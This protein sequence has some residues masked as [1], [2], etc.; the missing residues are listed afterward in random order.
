LIKKGD[1]VFFADNSNGYL[2]RCRAFEATTGELGLVPVSYAGVG[3]NVRDS[4]VDREIRDSFYG[5]QAIVL[6]F[7]DL[8]DDE[9]DHADHWALPELEPALK[10]GLPCLVY[11]SNEFPREVLRRYGYRGEAKSFDEL[12]NDLAQIIEP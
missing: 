7:G 8:K 5:G 1:R 11:V 10:S 2:E 12:K 3:R 9:G 4:S 6:Y